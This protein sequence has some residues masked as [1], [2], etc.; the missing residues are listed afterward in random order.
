MRL[1]EA[2]ELGHTLISE[3]R[4]VF[5][6]QIIACGCAIGSVYAALKSSEDGLPD[7]LSPNLQNSSDYVGWL[8]RTYPW[9]TQ[10]AF[11]ALRSRFIAEDASAW[12]D[13]YA[14]A[15]S[16]LHTLGVPRLEIAKLI[17][18]DEPEPPTIEPVSELHS[19]TSEVCVG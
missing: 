12:R 11:G 10:A 19:T 3:R 4:D 14:E 15:I 9:T 2:M 13:S 1:S 17:R 18:Q 5:Y 6:S 7:R 8:G 16:S